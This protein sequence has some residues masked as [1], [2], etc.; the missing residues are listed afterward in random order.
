MQLHTS[1]SFFRRLI[2]LAL[3]AC[4]SMIHA[5]EPLKVEV[6][7]KPGDH[8]WKT[9]DTWTMAHAIGFQPRTEPAGLSTY[10]GD[11][12]HKTEAK[13]FFYQ[14]K[15]RDRWW[16]VDPEGHLFINVAMCSVTPGTSSEHAKAS[17]EKTFGSNEKWTEETTGMM[18]AN[19]FN[20]SGS[21][22]QDAL[23]RKASQRVTYCPNWN[24][25]S[26]YGKQR[27]GTFQKPGHTGYPNDAIFVFDPE[28]EAFAMKHAAKLAETKDDP[29]LLGHFSDNEL[30]V[31]LKSLD[32]FLKL[33]ENEHGYK[34]ASVWLKKRRGG[35][36]DADKLTDEDREDF[37]EFMMER[38]FAIVSKAIK[39]HDPNHLYLG[40][41][42]H[43]DTKSSSGA[44]RAAGM[45]CDVVSINHYG[46]WTPD[47]KQL[48]DWE[49]WSGKPFMITE[50]YA[51]GVDSGM[52]NNSGAGWLVKTQ[53][54]RGYFYQNFC[55]ALLESKSCVG[56]HHFKYQDNDM[57]NKKA[58]P[59]N[60]DSNKGVM[61]SDF[62][63]YQDFLERMKELNINVYGLT[64]WIDKG[65][66]V[67]P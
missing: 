26:S 17:F 63:I 44:F 38:Y 39:T 15:I 41:R 14:K 60:T 2:L 33:P 3:G 65:G 61:S 37:R 31:K 29:W 23:L 58:D 7:R 35:K 25:M 34:A 18:R 40:C 6:K 66:K 22:S 49:K 59:S 45:H 27:G 19:G 53:K 48:A 52:P 43:G 28:F 32:S 20:G 16:L 5:S 62:V 8:V 47:F 54:E 11:L 51:K 30:P 9:Y 36:A 12:S 64:E 50:Y 46:A 4:T 13:G 67:H 21:W 24:F 10:G 56:W 55:I 57:Q 1:Q 42:F